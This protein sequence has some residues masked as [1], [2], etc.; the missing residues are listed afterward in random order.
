MTAENVC[1]TRKTAETDI[2]LR[3][4]I[5]DPGTISLA[6]GIPFLDHM[7]HTL[8]FHGGMSLSVTASGD[9][10]VDLHHLVED[11]GI[12]LGRAL[13]KHTEQY[14]PVRRFGHAVI[15][16]DEAL[17]EVTIDVSGRAHLACRGEYPQ[18]YCGNFDT[19]LIKEFLLG[20]VRDADI[21]LHADVRYGENSHHMA[22][23]LFKAL[24]KCI[25]LAFTPSAGDKIP[26]TK[27]V[28]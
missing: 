8:A 15:P 14:G 22:E 9:T 3:L 6:T 24:G 10:D 18:Q 19:V 11:I 4:N 21:T 13:K 12:V 5:L 1:V 26:S 20:L 28:M 23:S 7:L 16:M 25:S 17:S 2:S 27:G